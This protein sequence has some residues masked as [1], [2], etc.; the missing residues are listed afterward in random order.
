MGLQSVIG[1]VGLGS[2]R[3]GCGK[4]AGSHPLPPPPQSPFGGEAARFRL[5]VREHAGISRDELVRAHSVEG[6]WG[7]RGSPCRAGSVPGPSSAWARRALLS[8]R[9]SASARDTAAPP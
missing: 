4:V 5:E 9:A 3:W 2:R 8:V 6:F 7:A 1:R